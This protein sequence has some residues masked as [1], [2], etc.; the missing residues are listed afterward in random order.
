MK[1]IAKFIGHEKGVNYIIKT[2]TNNLIS[3]GD[4][5]LIK[6]WPIINE[7]NNKEGSIKNI[8]EI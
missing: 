7:E 1:Q 2:S 4:D 6:I 8:F 3:H 5:S